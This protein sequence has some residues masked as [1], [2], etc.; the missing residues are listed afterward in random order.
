ME[1]R[2][3]LIVI[4]A[5]KLCS[6]DTECTAIA[7][8]LGAVQAQIRGQPSQAYTLQRPGQVWFLQVPEE[9][10]NCADCL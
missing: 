2:C 9:N 7:A 1:E 10:I 6:A 4:F 8:G 5:V 3:S